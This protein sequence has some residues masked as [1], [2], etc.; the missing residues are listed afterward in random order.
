MPLHVASTAFFTNAPKAA[1]IVEKLPEVCT[2]LRSLLY[3]SAI[4]GLHRVELPTFTLA[5]GFRV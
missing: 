5:L 1:H 3:T 2:K 4:A